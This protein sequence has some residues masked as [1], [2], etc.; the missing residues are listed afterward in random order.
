MILHRMYWMAYVEFKCPFKLATLYLL[1][2]SQQIHKFSTKETFS[3]AMCTHHPKHMK[4]TTFVFFH[5]P[6]KLREI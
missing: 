1:A 5:V 4:N 3:I 6:E 2:K